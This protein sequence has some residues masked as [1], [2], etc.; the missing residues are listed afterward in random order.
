VDETLHAL[1]RTRV[2]FGLLFLLRTTPLGLPLGI[3]DA[4]S[5]WPLLGWP[6]SG[7]RGHPPFSL[8][9]SLVI[10]LC[11]VRTL[12]AVAFTGGYR[13]RLSGLAAGASGFA[14]MSQEPFAFNFTL[15]LLCLAPI[16]LCFTDCAAVWTRWPQP[17]HAPASSVWLLC[18]FVAS[19][20]FWA[21]LY[22]LRPDW[23]DGRA[24][25]LYHRD[26]AFSSALA[27]ALLATPTRR[28]V[29]AGCVALTELSLVPLLLHPR[30]RALGVALGLAFHLAIQLVT[31]PDVLGLEMALLLLALWPARTTA[32]RP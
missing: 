18:A 15:H 11:L 24:L 16:V 5:A 6:A 29:V 25:A 19:I 13:V 26:G 12:A 31:S 17:A 32:R 8:P 21:G 14:V 20:Y 22:K 3:G 1:A 10:A 7:F 23:L 2:A 27:D 4:A 30:T 9:A 28:A